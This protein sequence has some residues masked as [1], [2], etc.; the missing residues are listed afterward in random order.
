MDYIQTMS[1]EQNWI[2]QLK[3]QMS[4]SGGADR[5]EVIAVNMPAAAGRLL[6]RALQAAQEGQEEAE[7][8]DLIWVMTQV[9][10]V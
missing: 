1:N 4:D 8:A 10:K 5:M 7:V 3:T 6:V 9:H 2:E